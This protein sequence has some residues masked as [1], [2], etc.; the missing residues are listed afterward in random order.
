MKLKYKGITYPDLIVE[1]D[2]E[3]FDTLIP[4][5]TGDYFLARI[6]SGGGYELLEFVAEADVEI[7]V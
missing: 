4:E 5:P 2:A 1:G 3:V 6:D 7:I